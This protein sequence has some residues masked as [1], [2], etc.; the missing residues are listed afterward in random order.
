M[1]QVVHLLDRVRGAID[2]IYREVLKFGAVGAVA[3]VVDLGVF[4]L[5]RT[6]LLT[7]T[8]PLAHKPLTAK[9][10]SVAVATV[11]AWLG[12]RYWTFRHRRRSVPHREFLLFV[13][14]N[15][16]GLLIAL[17]CL[18][19]SHYLLGL[20]SAL[21]DNISG[22]VVGLGLG[23]LFR[24]WAY[25]TFVFTELRGPGLTGPHLPGVPTEEG[26]VLARAD[27]RGLPTSEPAGPAARG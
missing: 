5:L 21:A 2:I 12:N 24:F 1:G 8:G 27:E 3:F 18:A 13:L 16:V 9:T 26:P 22:N 19:S 11:V 14:M 25:R 10:I 23:T 20:R 4:N 17:A 15:V 6:G 7:D